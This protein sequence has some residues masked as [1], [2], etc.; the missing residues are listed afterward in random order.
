[1]YKVRTLPVRFATKKLGE[2]RSSHSSNIK[3]QRFLASSPRRTQPCI[4]QIAAFCA[5]VWHSGDRLGSPVRQTRLPLELDGGVVVLVTRGIWKN[6]LKIFGFTRGQRLEL[7][8]STDLLWTPYI[9]CLKRQGVFFSP[10]RSKCVF[11]AHSSPLFSQTV[12]ESNG[13]AAG[14][15][16]LPTLFFFFFLHRSDSSHM[17][18]LLSG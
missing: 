13:K 8:A 18:I 10:K 15:K 11:Y 12:A 1:M 6:E 4:F 3:H 14:P 5:C 9:Q 7:T 16:T 2:D 17:W